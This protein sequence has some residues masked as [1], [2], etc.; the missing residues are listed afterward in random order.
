ME[1]LD[2]KISI[3][4][5]KGDISKSWYLC[6]EVFIDGRWREKRI[7]QNCNRIK[8]KRKRLDLL[9]D[10]AKAYKDLLE[11]GVIPPQFREYVINITLQSKLYSALEQKEREGELRGDTITNYRQGVRIFIKWLGLKNIQGISAEDFGDELALEYWSWLKE[12]SLAATTKN[13]YLN[14][15]SSVWIWVDDRDIWDFKRLK[16]EPKRNA[17]FTKD[18]LALIL[19]DLKRVNHGAYLACL[20][21]YYGGIRTGDINNMLVR[22]VYFE[23]NLL[24][25]PSGS[26]K[27]RQERWISLDEDVM[28]QL[29]EHIGD[30]SPGYFVFGSL[31]K[32]R[33]GFVVSERKLYKQS[34]NYFFRGC[35]RR[36]DLTEYNYTVHSFRHYAAMVLDQNGANLSEIQSYMG[37]A[38]S[39]TTEKYRRRLGLKSNLVKQLPKLPSI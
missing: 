25:I 24:Y 39:I 9:R 31:G 36:L 6:V 19:E 22:D 15:L 23:R 21:V 27:G 16:E 37:H 2:F 29:R 20:L 5:Y 30:A 28:A 3:R 12:Q 17:P 35:L 34:I 18:H 4:D 7:T 26:T 33:R 38:R 1:D 10:V 13:D 14:F 32:G 11:K 8:N